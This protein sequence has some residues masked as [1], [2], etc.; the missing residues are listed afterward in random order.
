MLKRAAQSR[1]EQA[2]IVQGDRRISY[3]QLLD[4]TAAVGQ[5]LQ[6]LGIHATDCV[7]VVLPN[8]P[9]FI[10]SLFACA[11]V[12][13]VMSPLNPQYTK[14]ELQ[15]FLLDGDVQVIITDAL[16]QTV[17]REI[18]AELA[19]PIQLVVV[20]EAE[21]GVINFEQ[22]FA[23][24][25]F[26]EVEERRTAPALYLYTSGSTSAYKRVCCTQENLF[27]EALNFVETLGLTADDAILCTVPL[28][29]SYGFGNGLLD[30]VYAGSTLVLMAQVFDEN[31]KLVEAPF[32]SR[33][34][35]VIDLL[36]QEGIRFFPGVPYQFKAL[37]DLPA[38]V[39]IDLSGLKWCI[40]SGDV[41]PKSTYESFLAR[42]GIAIRSLYGST[43]A[44]SIC[45]NTDANIGKEG[46][47]SLGLP[48]HNV[49]IQ[50]RD[51]SGQ[52]LP[53]E[54]SGAIWVKSPV[55]PPTGYENRS[56]LNSQVFREG[57]YDTGDVGKKAANGHLLITGRKQTFV[58]VGGYKVDIGEL[59]EV[60]L[61]HPQVREAAAVG[62][63]LPHA[64]QVIK[65]VIVAQGC[66]QADAVL[67]FCRERLAAYKVPA[68]L[69]FREELPRSPL[70]KVLKN[71]LTSI[72]HRTGFDL[73]AL[74]MPALSDLTHAQQLETVAVRVQE[75]V[76][77]TLRLEV[78][79]I[80][81]AA[82]FQSLGFDSIRAAELHSRLLQ[83][84]G[85]PLSITL[86]WNHPSI[87]ELTA[88]L[89]EKLQALLDQERTPLSRQAN[90]KLDTTE[91]YTSLEQLIDWLNTLTDI[92]VDAFFQ[93]DAQSKPVRMDS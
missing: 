90:A 37:A 82:S 60:L 59:E 73:V 17:C 29:H 22:L 13:A 47:G 10:I 54:V 5:G 91:H 11:R 27:Y 81:H 80:S 58:D 61:S 32:I 28:Y 38:E 51:E 31:A 40:S 69:E 36:Q 62:V 45:L 12:G 41:L 15:R 3:T 43:E 46:F 24:P 83:L 19:R 75:Q 87:A 86:M 6:E 85:L 7:A 56:E 65:A 68:M 21:F 52:L 48:L 67:A 2:A 30:A 72:A 18:I 20:G 50:I 26:D 77:A 66:C 70:G 53:D 88:V 42:F 39:Q 4:Q 64:G 76:A 8:C 1:P 74:V 71:E 89:V 55:I 84:T 49:E 78:A 33:T 14:D 25:Q 92:E 16:R 79:Q 63:E 34:Q 23:E 35:H 44:G 57:Y 93:R 9:E